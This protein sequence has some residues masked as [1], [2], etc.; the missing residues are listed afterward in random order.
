MLYLLDIAH[1]IVSVLLVC[2]I[3]LQRRSGGL[4]PTFGGEG[5]FY[6]TR[7]GLERGLFYATIVLAI[8]FIALAV[9]N[10]AFK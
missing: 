9:L 8:L 5:G 7:R 10:I 6:R 3:L 1:I 4:S 2:A